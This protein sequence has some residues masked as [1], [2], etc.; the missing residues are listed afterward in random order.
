MTNLG[1]LGLQNT[2]EKFFGTFQGVWGH[3]PPENFENGASQIG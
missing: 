3:A 1:F 2:P